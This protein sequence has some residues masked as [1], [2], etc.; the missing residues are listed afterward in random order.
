MILEFADDLYRELF[1]ELE[2]I[3]QE[4]ITSKLEISKKLKVARSYLIK[5][6][7]KAIAQSFKDEQEEIT[8]F[9]TK[10]PLFVSHML[11][12][13]VRQRM[14]LTKP[15]TTAEQIKKYYRYGLKGIEKF[16]TDNRELYTYYRSGADHLD[17]LLFMRYVNEPP[18][19]LCPARVDH[20]ERFSTPADYLI[21]KII[22]NEHLIRY[23]QML[24]SEKDGNMETETAADITWTGESINLLETAYGW[25]CTGQIN[26][27]QAGIGKIVRKLETVFNVKIGRPYR[28]FAE[29][30][31]RKRLSRTK[32]MDEM[33][34]A[35]VK[36][37][38]DEDEYRPDTQN[39]ND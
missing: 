38:D 17:R 21:A 6:K 26:N 18:S 1:E 30:K 10:K 36:K 4:P 9:K 39:R 7:D 5:L 16:Y 28:R 19:W 35:I 15:E 37:L 23:L 34:K 25:Y 2:L 11:Y 29:I 13:L 32:F 12:L 22:S 27:G 31:Q 20:D 3:E 8:F 33:S 14:E 24:V